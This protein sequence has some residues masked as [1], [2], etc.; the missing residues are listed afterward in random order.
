MARARLCGSSVSNAA[1]KSI[2]VAFTSPLLPSTIPLML[3]N[4]IN[5]IKINT[6]LMSGFGVGL[7]WAT[8]IYKRK[9]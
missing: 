3:T 4:Y 7:S 6:I 8:S 1:A 2:T 5:N 9:I